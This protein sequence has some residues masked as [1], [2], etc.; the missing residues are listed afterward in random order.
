MC[1]RNS[2]MKNNVCNYL[3]MREVFSYAQGWTPRTILSMWMS[4]YWEEMWRALSPTLNVQITC[5]FFFF[6]ITYLHSGIACIKTP[7]SHKMEVQRTLFLGFLLDFVLIC[8]SV[9]NLLRREARKFSGYNWQKCG[10]SRSEQCSHPCLLKTPCTYSRWWL[11]TAR[12]CGS[13]LQHWSRLRCLLS[14]CTGEAGSSPPTN[15]GQ[16]WLTT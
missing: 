11:L 1:L 10:C 3:W 12:A 14:S 2:D 8:S 5:L 4:E 6:Q 7:I 15:D 13:P 16:G 9:G